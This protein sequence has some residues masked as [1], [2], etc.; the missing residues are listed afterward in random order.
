MSEEVVGVNLEDDGPAE[1][2]DTPAPVA[3]TPAEAPPEEAKPAEVEAVE[4]AGQKYVPL[5]GIVSERKQRQAAEKT[6]NE[7][8]ARLQQLEQQYGQI[9]PYAEILKNNPQ[10]LSPRQPEPVAAPDPADDPDLVELAQTLD[11]YD[12][13]TGKPDVKKAEKIR[14]INRKEAERIA[15]TQVQPFQ[16]QQIT[17]RVSQNY[18]MALNAKTPDGEP[19]NRQVFDDL[20]RQAAAEPG[21]MRTLSDPRSV[22]AL[23]LMA[24][25]AAAWSAQPKI[26]APPPALET[27]ASG[28]NPRTRP[29]LS[30]ME[31]RIAADKG[32]APSKWEER[33]KSFQKGGSNALED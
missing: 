3:E 27:E 7:T 10:L 15:Q 4:V 12:P 14:N 33:V 29:S 23:V 1:F 8:Q 28:G 21:G 5:A 26:A 16:E 17:A 2:P 6:L 31:E 20:W 22:M 25:G 9:A 30:P 11:L 24:K 19:L 32:V 13:T 18:A